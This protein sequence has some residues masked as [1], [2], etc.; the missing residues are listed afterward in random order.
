MVN[1]TVKAAILDIRTICDVNVI[2]VFEEENSSVKVVYRL[3]LDTLVRVYTVSHASPHR[4]IIKV[5][6]KINADIVELQLQL[7]RNADSLYEYKMRI[8]K[9]EAETLKIPF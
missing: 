8:I 1:E 6:E 4:Q 5:I 2:G 3:P 7:A 9:L